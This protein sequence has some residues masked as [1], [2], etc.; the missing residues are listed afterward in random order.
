MKRDDL[1]DFTDEQKELV[2][3]LYG[4]AISKKEKEIETLKADK[5][6]LEGNNNELKNQINSLNE[7]IEGNNKSL[8][9]MEKL[10]SE[11][12]SLK[13]DIEL[14]KSRVKDEFSKFVKSEVLSKVNDDIDFATALES[15]KKESP[16]YFGDTV[17]KKVQSAPTLNGGG[18][19]TKTTSD[20]MNDI[21]RGAKNNNE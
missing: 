2:M 7:T 20:I 10:T 17:I 12:S 19:P 16:Q 18:A 9:E 3:S 11:N 14:N 1:V 4:K 21:L 13:A 5:K 15:Y 8:E 6:E